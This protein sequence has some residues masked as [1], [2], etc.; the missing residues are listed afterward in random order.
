MKRAVFLAV[1]GFAHMVEAGSDVEYM[2][3]RIQACRG[4]A[5]NEH[6]V[7]NVIYFHPEDVGP[8]AGFRERIPRIMEDIQNF[9]RSEM[10]RNGFGDVTFPLDMLNGKPRIHV[11]KGRDPASEYHYKSGRKVVS[12]IE[13]ALAGKLH[14][15]REF[16][17]IFH[18]MCRKREDG[19]YFFHAPYYGQRSSNHRQGLC[20]VADCELQDPK[21]L[22]ETKRR[23][24]YEEH[25]GKF[26]Q[27]LAQFNVKYLGGVAHELGHGLGL[28]H[29]GQTREEARRLGTALMG[30]GNHTYRREVLGGKGSFLTL[31]SATRLASHPLFA[32]SDRGIEIPPKCQPSELTF[33]ADNS[34][35]IIE[36]TVESIPEAYAIIA[37][38]DPEGKADYDALSYVA[39][40]RQGRFNIRA[41]CTTSGSQKLRL[42]ACHVN[43][44]MSQFHSATFSAGGRNE[45]NAAT[46]MTQWLL[47]GIEQMFLQGSEEEAA[48]R[49]KEIL[50]EGTAPV[51][52]VPKL[53]HVV[54]LAAVRA[55]P[56]M[57]ADVDGKEVYLSDLQWI[58]AQV[59]WGKPTRDRYYYDE[60][61][62]N[63]LFLELGG[64]FYEKGLY[65]HAPSRYVFDI[66]TRFKCFTATVGLQDGTPQS[67]TAVFVVKGDGRELFR[68]ELLKRPKTVAIDLSI[69]GVKNL[70]LLVESGKQGN[71]YCWSLWGAPKISR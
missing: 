51:P 49:A 50:D 66:G 54:A 20:H 1:I 12:E 15:G 7:L 64:E 31:A 24:A 67:G 40:V 33:A 27:S 59:G 5:T 35:L 60:H 56:I 62:H 4:N 16:V 71:A 6:R 53:K 32:R 25:Y 55:K 70:E 10:K 69:D 39:P 52:A 26:E 68:S 3:D 17:L 2:R 63:V 11:V 38:V 23:I 43:G 36:G 41:R 8:Q 44:D 19:S 34:E 42:V 46:L 47:R 22:T 65:A 21:L 18:G 57:P 58:S 14:L 45:P 30:A 13:K 9:Y 29:N 37:Y 28:P 48:K 61:V